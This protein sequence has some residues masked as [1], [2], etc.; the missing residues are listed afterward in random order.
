M[1]ARIN[2]GGSITQLDFTYNTNTYY[3]VALV[4]NATSSKLFVNGVLQDSD[5]TLALPT[6]LNQLAFNRASGT[7][8]MEGNVKQVLYFPEALSDADCITLTT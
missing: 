4:Y 6:G 7:T 3:K 5:T 1:S 2:G 8:E